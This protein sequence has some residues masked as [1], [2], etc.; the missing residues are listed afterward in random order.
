MIL[1]RMNVELS[2]ILVENKLQF[3]DKTIKV[4]KKSIKY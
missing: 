4:I 2:N 1:S 3:S